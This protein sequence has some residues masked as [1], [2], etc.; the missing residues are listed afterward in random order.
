MGLWFGLFYVREHSKAQPTGVLVLKTSQK[1]G[2][3]GI[4]LGPL[5]TRRITYTLHHGGS[6]FV[7]VPW[8]LVRFMFL[9]F[10]VRGTRRLNR[11]CFWFEMSQKTGPRLR[12]SSLRALNSLKVINLVQ[13]RSWTHCLWPYLGCNQYWADGFMGLYGS[14]RKAQQAVDLVLKSLGRR[15]MV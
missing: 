9:W 3:P 4:E 7:A 10:N 13:S 12:V 2:E 5:G 6:R 11:Q 14:T 8:K 1:T 15:V